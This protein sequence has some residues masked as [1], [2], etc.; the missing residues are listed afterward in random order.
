MSF[1][2][3]PV[4]I[5]FGDGKDRSLRYTVGTT[6]KLHEQY[7]GIDKML[8]LRPFE[9]IPVLL[10]GIPAAEKADITVESLEDSIDMPM[11]ED[12]MHAFYL[13]FTGKDLKKMQEEAAAKNEPSSTVTTPT[14]Q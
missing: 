10:A 12:L 5:N 14:I 11:M 8:Q 2:T 13:A 1:P 3:T 9:F 6:K 4:K 7:G